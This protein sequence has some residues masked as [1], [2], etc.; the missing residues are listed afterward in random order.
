MIG[1]GVGML[2][3]LISGM[4]RKGDI[5]NCRIFCAALLRR[6]RDELKKKS[7]LQERAKGMFVNQSQMG[8]GKKWMDVVSKDGKILWQG[9]C[10]C[11]YYAKT[12]A[13]D[14][15]LNE[16]ESSI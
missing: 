14:R 10:C 15:L 8:A 12:K 13:I 3:I 9:T 16:N 5:M 4:N 1:H 11:N 7:D 2:W 6:S